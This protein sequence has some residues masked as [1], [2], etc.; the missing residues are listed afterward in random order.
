[1]SAPT[2]ETIRKLAASDRVN[3]FDCGQPALNQYLQRFALNNQQANSAQTYVACADGAV[4]AFYCLAVGSVEA[5]AA[6][7]RIS[8]GM[9]QHS[10][11]VMLLARLAVDLRHQGLGLGQA[12]LKDALLR[13]AHAAD[14]AGIRA[15]LV[16]AKDEAARNWYL[17]WEFEPGITDPF[18]LFQLLKDLKRLVPRGA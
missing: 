3:E 6:T 5:R 11:P 15:L 9:S 7:P 2:Y 16:H 8:K 12:M 17:Q 18:H 10:V 4:V 1:M 14:I 13:T